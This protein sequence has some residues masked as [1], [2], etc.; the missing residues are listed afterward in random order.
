MPRPKVIMCCQ[1]GVF[2]LLAV[3]SVSSRVGTL[4]S[5]DGAALTQV[6][7]VVVE[8]HVPQRAAGAEVRAGAV[9]IVRARSAVVEGR[10]GSGL[11]RPGSESSRRSRLAVAAAPVAVGSG[12]DEV[13]LAGVLHRVVGHAVVDAVRLAREVA[14]DARQGLGQRRPAVGVVLVVELLVPGLLVHAVEL[15]DLQVLVGLDR[16]SAVDGEE[17][18]PIAAVDRRK[19]DAGRGLHRQHA[20]AVVREPVAE[21]LRSS[22]NR[23]SCWRRSS[24]SPCAWSGHRPC[25]CRSR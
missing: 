24:R 6:G 13:L 25:R 9:G 16:R 19:R 8:R 10:V 17:A 23:C 14:A 21:V 7:L 3:D 5:D 12:D 22:A 1:F 11:R 18:D 15:V 20:G 2:A 4:F